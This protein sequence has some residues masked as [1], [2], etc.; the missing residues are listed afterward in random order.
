M[1]YG[2]LNSTRHDETN[3]LSTKK[4]FYATTRKSYDHT[5]SDLITR[6]KLFMVMAAYRGQKTHG[7]TCLY[8][9]MPL[10]RIE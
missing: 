2:F 1:Y 9:V 3:V 4:Y 7:H 8:I 5:I 6:I 10:D